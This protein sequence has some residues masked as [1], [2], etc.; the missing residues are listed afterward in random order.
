MLQKTGAARSVDLCQQETGSPA[1]ADL[2]RCT[3][4]G[5][6][7]IEHRKVQLRHERR[8]VRNDELIGPM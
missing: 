4:G 1:R 5:K 7:E 6:V 8:I 2:S 3:E